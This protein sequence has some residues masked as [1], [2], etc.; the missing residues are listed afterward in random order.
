[1]ERDGEQKIEKERN[2]KAQILRTTNTHTHI[3]VY[4]KH[5]YVL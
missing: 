2:S 1:M 5:I 3:C 4:H